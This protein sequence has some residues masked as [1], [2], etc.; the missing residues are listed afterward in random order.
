MDIMY[1]QINALKKSLNNGH[2]N[3]KQIL[4]L[5]LKLYKTQS[6]DKWCKIFILIFMIVTNRQPLK[7]WTKISF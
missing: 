1:R 7:I 5:D 4:K 6:K 2:N 3:S